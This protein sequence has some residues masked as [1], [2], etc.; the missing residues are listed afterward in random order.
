M[1][2][3]AIARSPLGHLAAPSVGTALMLQEKPFHAMVALRVDLRDADA[4]SAV[5]TA[6]HAALPDANRTIACAGGSALWLG[7]DEFL[8]VTEPGGETALTATLSAA[9]RGRRGAVVD[10]SDSRTII[11]LSGRH[12]RDLL[13]KGSG[14]DL[15]PRSFGPGQC[16]QSFLAKVKIA[17]HQLDDAPSYHIIVERSVAEYL[18]L[19]LADAALEFAAAPP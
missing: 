7:P 12:A 19:W 15:H 9:L 3:T 16:A 2:D 1:A 13:A 5:E 14:L 8:I 18:F 11:A 10:I 6:L 4:R 17:L